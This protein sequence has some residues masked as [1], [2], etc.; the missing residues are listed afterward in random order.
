MKIFVGFGY[1]PHDRWVQDLVF[2]LIEAFGDEV[3]TGEDLQGEQIT[4][5]VRRKIQQ[6]DA[7]IGFVTRRNPDTPRDRTTHRWVTD[8]LT[9]GLL[10][11]IPVV[12]V[13]EVGVD[14]QGGLVGDRQRIVY[15]PTARDHCIVAIAKTI[16][17]WHRECLETII[18]LQPEKQVQAIA[19]LVGQA[20]L[21]CT[22]SLL[23]NYQ[24]GPPSRRPFYRSG[25]VCSFGPKTC[26]PER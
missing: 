22:F 23:L 14:E 26:H 13:R 12:E 25:E 10:C 8:E 24:E 7:L 18:Q 19:S 5:A 3:I 20:R 9:C 11:N 6:S 15:D 1:H 17:K 16:G 4:E 21:R 2:P